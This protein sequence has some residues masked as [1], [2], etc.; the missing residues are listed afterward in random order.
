ML[1][2][3]KVAISWRGYWRA[4]RRWLA[5]FSP[6]SA[7]SIGWRSSVPRGKLTENDGCWRNREGNRREKLYSPRNVARNSEKTGKK[8]LS[9]RLEIISRQKKSGAKSL[10]IKKSLSF[11]SF[12]IAKSNQI[13]ISSN[14]IVTYARILDVFISVNC[15]VPA[16]LLSTKIRAS[17]CFLR[18]KLV[19]SVLNRND[20]FSLRL[21][22]LRLWE[23]VV[24][25]VTA[26]LAARLCT[27][28]TRTWLSKSRE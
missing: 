12:V 5:L 28:S 9:H 17:I 6:S 3:T 22:S 1:C 18:V 2:E 13:M 15:R 16:Y 8:L 24:R 10:K 14:V 7:L 23:K 4:S 21:R 19:C 25:M 20:F 11:H 26:Y 27:I